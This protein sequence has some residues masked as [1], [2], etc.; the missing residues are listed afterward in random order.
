MYTADDP[1]CV[2]ANVEDNAHL[3][4]SEHDRMLVLTARGSHCA[5]LEG[6]LWPSQT[7][8]ADRLALDYL[9]AVLLVLREQHATAAA[10]S[11]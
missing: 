3:F 8:W 11:E 10:P 9:Q 2:L 7:S 4:D 5:H 6:L 1:V